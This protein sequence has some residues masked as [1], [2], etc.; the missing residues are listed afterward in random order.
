MA[1]GKVTISVDLDGKKAQGDVQSLKNSLTGLGAGFKSMLGANIVG[2]ALVGGIKAVGGALVSMGSELNSSQKAW[3]TFEGNLQAFGRSADTIASAKK[4]MQDFATKTIY[5]A[6]DMASTY[7]QLDAVG[8]KNVGSLVKAFGGLAASAENP[9]QA[10][11]SLST[12]ATQMASKPKIAW[13]DFKIM[14]EQAPAGMAAVAKEMGMSTADL[15]KAVQ[16]GK[17]STEDFFDAMNHAGNSDAFQKMA[18][19]F[20]TVDQAIDGAKESL[21][22]KLMPAFEHLNKFGIEAVNAVSNALDGINFDKFASSLGS[23]LSKIDVNAIVSKISSGISKIVGF[24]QIAKDKVVEFY[25]IF[26]GTG[27]AAGIQAA[28]EAIKNAIEHVFSSL[29]VKGDVITPLATMIGDAFVKVSSYIEEAANWISKLDP[30]IIRTVA[31][32]AA[33]AVA[34]FKGFKAVSGILNGVSKSFNLIKAAL[35]ANPFALAVVGIGALIGAFVSAYNSSETFRNKVDAVVGSVKKFIDGLEPGQLKSWAATIASVAG[36]FAIFKMLNGWNPFKKFGKNGKDALDEVKDALSGTSGEATKSKGI[37]EQVFTGLGNIIK[38]AGQGLGTAAKGIGTGLS[39]AFKGLGT[40]IATAA[41][42]I[43]PAISTIAQGIGTGLAT[44]FQG[45]GAAIAMVPP[46]TWLALGA[47]I[48]M[49][50]AAFALAGTQADGISQIFQTVGD[51]I[52]RILQQITNSLA[53]LIPIIT[54]SLATLVP[55]VA[56]AISQI[57]VAV[58]SGLATI[59]GAISGGIATIVSA[60]ANGFATVVSAVAGGIAQIIFA[61]SGLVGALSG[62]VSAIGGFFE[63]LGSGIQ[64]ALNGVANVLTAFGNAV[65]SILEGVGSVFESVGNSIKSIFEGIGDVIK[66]VGESIKSVLDGIAKVIESV[67]KAALNAGKGF[68]LLADGVV[69]I[70]NTKLGDMAASLSAVAKGVGEIAAQSGGLSEAGAGMQALGT[71]MTMLSFS[72]ATAVLGLAVFSSTITSIQGTT[73]ALPAMLTTA[74]A[75]F[76]SFSTQAVAGVAGLSAINVP[77]AS[78]KAQIMTITPALMS[79]SLGFSVFSSQAMIIS[80][81]FAVVGALVSAFNAR[82]MSVSIAVAVAGASFTV[83][84][85]SVTGLGTALSTVSAG[86]VQVGASST[87]AAVQ[88]R[89]MATSTQTV[90]AAFNSMRGQIQSSMQA[91]LTVIRSVGAQMKSQGQQIGIQTAHNLAQGIRSGVGQSTSAMQALMNAVRSTGMAGVGAMRGIGAMIGQ[92]L[93]AGMYSALGAVTAAANALVAQAERAAQA[94]AKI[95][96]PSRLF[97]DNVGRFISQG[98]AVGITADAYKVDDAIGSMYEQIQ[99]FNFSAEDVIGVGRSKLSKVV[100]VKS[101]LES[102]VKATVEVSKDKA[103]NLAKEALDV[104]EKAV[105]RPVYMVL[106]D[107]TLVAKTGDRQKA[108]QDNKIKISNR[109]NGVTAW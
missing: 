45:L 17:V 109:M 33:G 28:F 37:I 46:T 98:V 89:T 72:A 10:M 105:K 59:I 51:V 18:T 16:D 99:A 73:T 47:A 74:A 84:S 78:F 102:A 76:A 41:K 77:I 39:T 23:V 92:G 50:G 30:G 67:G 90:I 71:G 63:S 3:K 32:A 85:S 86:F 8:T 56:S 58:S 19:E 57:V 1:D 82:M 62:F 20:K 27:A 88:V 11:K 97:R 60:F 29:Q 48:L 22:N 2:S 4:E 87:S 31:G 53:T 9:A 21:A 107:G 5:S 80:G 34:A 52:V 61:F 25:E 35:S 70:T 106:D 75:S 103:N 42:A 91:I 100:Q 43:G 94:K 69:R 36:G 6:S 15:V 40:G 108:Y 26:K 44:A 13:M 24:L 12:Q 65:Q 81:T 79:A 83:L 7:S 101:D 104:A 95:H 54:S 64:S 66:S 38:S 96:S 14:M 68:D 49:V 55:I 93:A